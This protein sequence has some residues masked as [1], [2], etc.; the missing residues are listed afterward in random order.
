MHSRGCEFYKTRTRCLTVATPCNIGDDLIRMGKEQ[1]IA[2]NK[3][4][5][6]RMFARC[7]D[8][9]VVGPYFGE[10]RASYLPAGAC[11]GRVDVAVHTHPSRDYAHD[12]PD[13]LSYR[14]L[15]SAQEV[16]TACI[17]YEKSGIK[18]VKCMQ[19]PKA[20]DAQIEDM[21]QKHLIL[22]EKISDSPQRHAKVRRLYKANERNFNNC[23]RR[24]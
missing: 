7:E 13:F 20:A 24:I 8:G 23:V 22:Q 16:N 4:G 18:Y 9:S 11:K 2:T 14:D 12:L 6:E 17:V 10:H 5:D 21:H 15:K 19:V 1:M 3:D